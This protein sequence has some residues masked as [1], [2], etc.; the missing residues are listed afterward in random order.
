MPA[1]VAPSP[2]LLFVR[3]P[4]R[5]TAAGALP[6]GHFRCPARY[7]GLSWPFSGASTSRGIISCIG[8]A[9]RPLREIRSTRSTSFAELIHML[10]AIDGERRAGDEAGFV[11]DQE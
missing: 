10:A 5:P 7:S 1:G 9:S 3:T 6:P 2:S 8:K 4:P 11:G